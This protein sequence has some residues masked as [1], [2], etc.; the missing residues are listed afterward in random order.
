M[1]CEM[2]LRGSFQGYFGAHQRGQ[3]R[4]SRSLTPWRSAGKHS[5]RGSR[6]AGGATLAR[7]EALLLTQNC[8][9]PRGPAHWMGNRGVVAGGRVAD[10]KWA[11][12]DLVGQ[13]VIGASTALSHHIERS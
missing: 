6:S 12:C 10:K 3:K 11:Q 13:D 9:K 7:I 5:C 4:I 1:G 8:L 2:C